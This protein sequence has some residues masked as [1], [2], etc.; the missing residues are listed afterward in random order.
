MSARPGIWRTLGRG[1]RGLPGVVLGAQAGPGVVNL[2][3]A[4]AEAHLAYSP[5]VVIAG[6]ISRCDHAK[7]TFQEVDQVALFAPISKR[8]VMVSDAA[9]LAPILEDAIRLANSGRRGPVVLHVPRD[10]FAEM[11]PAIEPTSVNIARPG[12][13]A[14]QDV[15][16]IATLLSNAERAGHFRRGW[17]QMGKRARGADGSGGKAGNPGRRPQPV[18]A[19]VMRHGHAWFAGQAG[20]RGNRVASRLT[21]EADVMLVLGARLGFNSTFHSYDYVGGRDPHRPY[22]PSTGPPLA[23]ISRPKL[24]CRPTR[25]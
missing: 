14:P 23:A 2:V 1:M 12:P 3:T 5:L 24:P 4:V 11:V 8:S 10:L 7:D 22:R 15:A 21:K 13:A 6:A 17:L 18:H 16:A 19:D 20:P 25:D 9:R